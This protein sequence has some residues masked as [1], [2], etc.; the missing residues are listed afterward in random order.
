MGGVVRRYKGILIIINATP[1]VLTLFLAAE[2][3]LL[4]S[5]KK[6]TF[7]LVYV[8]FVQYI[9]NFAQRTFKFVQKLSSGE[10]N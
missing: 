8:I 5:F 7:V 9:A 6:N 4:C 2:S 1:L 10:Y 3:L